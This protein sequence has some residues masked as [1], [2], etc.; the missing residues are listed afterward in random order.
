MHEEC[1]E[2]LL[3]VNQELAEAIRQHELGL[4]VIAVAN[5]GHG[6]VAAELPA[7]AVV[8]AMGATPVRSQTLELVA[9]EALELGVVLLHLSQ[10]TQRHHHPY[11]L[12]LAFPAPTYIQMLS[13]DVTPQ[14]S[15]RYH[16]VQSQESITLQPVLLGTPF[17]VKTSVTSYSPHSLSKNLDCMPTI[18]P[19]QIGKVYP[20]RNSASGVL[21]VPTMAIVGSEKKWWLLEKTGKWRV[22]WEVLGDIFVLTSVVTTFYYLAVSSEGTHTLIIDNIV[23]TFFVLDFLINCL[24]VV[25]DSKGRRIHSLRY[26]LLAYLKSDMVWDFI[27]ILP[28]RFANYPE[29]EYYLRIIRI[30]KVPG[31]LNFVDESGIGLLISYVLNVGKSENS[32]DVGL[33]SK[34]IGL[35]FQLIAELVLGT[36]LLGCFWLWYSDKVNHLPSAGTSFMDQPDTIDSE[37]WEL[38]ERAWYFM[39]TTMCTIGYGDYRALNSYEQTCLIGLLFVGVAV[40]SMTIGKINSMVSEYHALTAPPDYTGEMMQWMTMLQRRYTV[41]PSALRMRIMKHFSH[42]FAVDCLKS[43]GQTWKT[44]E[45]LSDLSLSDPYLSGLDIMT[46]KS[47]T[48]YLFG[49]LFVKYKMFFNIDRDFKYEIAYYFQPRRF[50]EDEEILGEEEE[51]EEVYFLVSGMVTCGVYAGRKQYVPL[52]TYNHRAVIGD[53]TALTGSAMP[54][55]YRTG[56]TSGAEMMVLP[57]KPLQ[58]LLNERFPDAK[59]KL[60]KQV[61]DKMRYLRMV[62]SHYYESNKS[63]R[64]SFLYRRFDSVDRKLDLGNTPAKKK[65]KQ[66]SRG[67]RALGRAIETMV[68]K[69]AAL[70]AAFLE[71]RSALLRQV[72][73]AFDQRLDKRLCKD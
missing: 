5:L 55:A 69:G 23:W 35:A 49:D 24:T 47:V 39:L 19:S 42:F 65:L 60:I 7:H 68:Q 26:I 11:L 70:R 22:V 10:T 14:A 67:L 9:L 53:Y 32:K 13:V 38:M 28:L 63:S 16:P 29:V 66:H 57:I 64:S 59:A 45:S 34:L 1:F 58:I 31:T 50:G 17:L 2:F 36:F 61:A 41:I 18:K 62:V 8:Y 44:C 4:L 21:R 73:T 3:V 37:N 48:D 25:E 71:K 15:P 6:T 72:I 43:L 54:V 40:F 52:L 30:R 56:K 12:P 46:V 20:R 51:T 33:T 27:A